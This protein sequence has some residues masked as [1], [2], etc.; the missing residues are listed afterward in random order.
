MRTSRSRTMGTSIKNDGDFCEEDVAAAKSRG[1]EEP[2][3]YPGLS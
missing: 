2:E 3:Y 1:A